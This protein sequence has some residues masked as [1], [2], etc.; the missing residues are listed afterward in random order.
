MSVAAHHFTGR[1]AQL[2][3]LCGDRPG[4]GLTMSFSQD[5][6]GSL[7]AFFGGIRLLAFTPA[8]T[9]F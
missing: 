2:K 4:D 9:S 7:K 6:L 3:H 8:N 1:M 5:N